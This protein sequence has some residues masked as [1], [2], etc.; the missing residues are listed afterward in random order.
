MKSNEYLAELQRKHSK[1]SKLTISDKCQEYLSS[2]LLTLHEKHFL[3]S[4]RC[5]T[6]NTKKNF[7][8]S[9]PDQS[10]RFCGDIH[11]DE[12]LDHFRD[13]PQLKIAIPEVSNVNP[14]DIFGD[15]QAQIKSVKVWIKVFKK[16]E[17]RETETR[18]IDHSMPHVP[19]VENDH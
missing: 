3:F 12:S 9:Y 1:T 8:G 5:R 17:D 13:C 10:C 6:S 16:L 4:L 11:S 18:R 7:P 14:E 2:K 15:L 19:T